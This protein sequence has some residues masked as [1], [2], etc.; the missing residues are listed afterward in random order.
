MI[1]NGK[2]LSILAVLALVFAGCAQAEEE[3]DATEGTPTAEASPAVTPLSNG[4][5]AQFHGEE[6]VSGKADAELELDDFYFG[7]TILRGDPRQDLTLTLHNEGAEL[8]NF[9]LAEQ[10]IDTDVTAGQSNVE[11]KV[12]FPDSGGLVFTCKY[13]AAD[14]GMRGELTTA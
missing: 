10:S 8:H 4:E 7:P 2:L 1:R 11:V 6:D 12:K 5:E 9:T 3:P 13:H 14:S